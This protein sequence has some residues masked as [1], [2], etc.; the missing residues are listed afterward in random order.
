MPFV[1]PQLILPVPT[2]VRRSGGG[3]S[4]RF[5]LSLFT[6]CTPLSQF[7]KIWSNPTKATETNLWYQKNYEKQLLINEI[8]L[9]N[10]KQKVMVGDKYS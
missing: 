10:R 2:F 1:F 6:L 8:Y 3:F 7:G 9:H 5:C 4:K